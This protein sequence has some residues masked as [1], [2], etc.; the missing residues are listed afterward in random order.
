MSNK[1]E[2][3]RTV[4]IVSDFSLFACFLFQQ[5]DGKFCVEMNL[6]FA[7]ASSFYVLSYMCAPCYFFFY[8]FIH[9]FI[10]HLLFTIFFL[11][12]H[13]PFAILYVSFGDCKKKKSSS[14]AHFQTE[15]IT[16]N[17]ITHF[18]SPL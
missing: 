12:S 14:I 2:V 16:T 4:F 7:F 13:F 6:N 18:I 5:A 17:V 10:I 1:H 8:L 3:P 15:L 9:S 11:V